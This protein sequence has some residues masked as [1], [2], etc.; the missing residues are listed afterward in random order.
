MTDF[1]CLIDRALLPTS[2]LSPARLPIS[3]TSPLSAPPSAG[4]PPTPGRS[5]PSKQP[6]M[7]GMRRRTSETPGIATR[8]PSVVSPTAPPPQD[9]GESTWRT[10]ADAPLPLNVS[11]GLRCLDPREG[12]GTPGAPGDISHLG[13]LQLGSLIITNGTASPAPS[14]RHSRQKKSEDLNEEGYFTASE[15]RLSQDSKSRADLSS[16]SDQFLS[17]NK[18]H[19]APGHLNLHHRSVSRDASEIAQKYLA[20]IPHSPF[21]ADRHSQ[22][23]VYSQATHA[24]EDVNLPKPLRS[25][26]SKPS[27]FSLRGL[28]RGQASLSNI[29]HG[30]S[31]ES[32]DLSAT[33]V[34]SYDLP[35][36]R[37]TPAAVC[38]N[39]TEPLK[40][41]VEFEFPA[42]QS[43]GSKKLQKRKVSSLFIPGSGLFQSSKSSL[44]ENP[45]NESTKTKSPVEPSPLSPHLHNKHHRRTFSERRELT[46]SSSRLFSGILS[47]RKRTNKEDAEN[48][49]S[50]THES[51]ELDINHSDMPLPVPNIQERKQSPSVRRSHSLAQLE[52]T[53]QQQRPQMVERE[54]FAGHAEALLRQRFDHHETTSSAYHPGSQQHHRPR[55]SEDIIRVNK[56]SGHRHAASNPFP[57]PPPG[58]VGKLQMQQQLQS[59]N[60]YQY[61]RSNSTIGH[62]QASGSWQTYPA[63]TEPAVTK[64]R[65]SFDSTPREYQPFRATPQYEAASPERFP[66]SYDW[67]RRSVSS[68]RLKDQDVRA[69]HGNAS[70]GRKHSRHQDVLEA[71]TLARA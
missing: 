40:Q 18:P 41:E 22:T 10:S 12:A 47:F 39:V 24:A 56:S 34:E 57:Q 67:S 1:S 6:S 49:L 4:L 15:G 55:Y 8:I 27:R 54:S 14:S 60:S 65:M 52:S 59:R 50:I 26:T 44:N 53:Q 63:T 30:F 70:Y 61:T 66:S 9:L 21:S 45:E 42:S 64:G 31:S 7:S 48:E 23:S 35:P 38:F 43:I 62:Y 3:R 33:S 16:G 37:V 20:E 25:V 2:S 51:H 32:T 28:R 19:A 13:A 46:H 68:P 5:S 17:S 29:R 71:T 36:P 11:S 58:L 69:T